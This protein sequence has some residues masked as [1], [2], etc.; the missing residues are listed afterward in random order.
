MTFVTK[1]RKPTNGQTSLDSPASS[2][3]GYHYQAVADPCSSKVTR[4]CLSGLC[5]LQVSFDIERVV[6]ATSGPTIIATKMIKMM[7]YSVAYRRTIRLRSLFCFIEKMGGLICRL[8]RSQ[9]R[10]TE[11]HLSM[12]GMQRT[13]RSRNSRRCERMKSAAKRLSSTILHKYSRP[14]CEIA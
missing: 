14:G 13:G 4:R 10:M 1:K 8:G 3:S 11:C 9:N 7:K 5:F 2:D 12:R 6:P